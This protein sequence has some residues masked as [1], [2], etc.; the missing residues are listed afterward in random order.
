MEKVMAVIKKITD[1]VTIVG[2]A[3]VAVVEVIDRAGVPIAEGSYQIAL[4]VLSA[5][6]SICS[7]IFNLVDKKQKSISAP[8]S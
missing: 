5:V 2:P 6:S 8:N 1:I 7:V 4:I 3:A